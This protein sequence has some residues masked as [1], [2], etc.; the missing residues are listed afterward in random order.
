MRLVQRAEVIQVG[1][2]HG[3]GQVR[4]EEVDL[5]RQLVQGQGL[6]VVTHTRSMASKYMYIKSPYT[7]PGYARS[8]GA[9]R[10]RVWVLAGAPGAARLR[11][12]ILAGAPGAAR[13]PVRV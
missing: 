10:L 6:A 4:I 3:D 13:L 8:P 11:V 5:G 7:R 2:G 9:V 1:H 12:R